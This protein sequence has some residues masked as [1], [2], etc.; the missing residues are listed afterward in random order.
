[1]PKKFTRLALIALLLVG[2]FFVSSNAN[3]LTLIAPTFE[4]DVDPG[5]A[6][7]TEIKLYNETQDT[8][9]LYAEV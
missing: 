8:L 3:A 1:M 9:T 2:G 6:S 7:K 5:I 4:Q